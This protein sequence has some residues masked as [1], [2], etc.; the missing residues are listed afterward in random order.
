M[1]APS[2]TNNGLVNEIN[3]LKNEIYSLSNIDNVSQAILDLKGDRLTILDKLDEKKEREEDGGI[4][5]SV[6]TLNEIVEQ[7][8]RLFDDVKN[9]L[10][11]TENNILSSVEV[12]GEAVARF[13]EQNI[14][15]TEGAKADRV[16]ILEDVAF[17]RKALEGGAVAALTTAVI[18]ESGLKNEND[19]AETGGEN[20]LAPENETPEQRNQFRHRKR[21]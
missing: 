9:L 7:L 21:N 6:P 16:K 11:D 4:V 19:S 12:I 10:A 15:F 1:V 2:P 5:A 20:S 18:K 8:D 13:T 17:I 14:Q 3:T